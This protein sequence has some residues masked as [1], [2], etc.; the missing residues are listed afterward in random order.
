MNDPGDEPGTALELHG[1]TEWVTTLA[2]C[3]VSV[4]GHTAYEGRSA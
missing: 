3:I 1:A 4:A 2:V